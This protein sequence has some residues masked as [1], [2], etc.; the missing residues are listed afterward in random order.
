VRT[1]WA[2]IENGF[3]STLEEARA[4]RRRAIAR[5]EVLRDPA[6]AIVKWRDGSFLLKGRVIIRPWSQVLT[7]GGVVREML[8][9]EPVKSPRPQRPADAP[10]RRR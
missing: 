2:E 8:A 10:R 5:G 1:I 9:G 6:P 7:R 3:Y 4:A